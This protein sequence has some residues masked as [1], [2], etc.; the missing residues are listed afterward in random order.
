MKLVELG[1]DLTKQLYEDL[2]Y[3]QDLGVKRRAAIRLSQ[4][5]L[6]GIVRKTACTDADLHFVH[7][8]RDAAVFLFA[9]WLAT[10]RARNSMVFHDRIRTE[11]GPKTEVF[12]QKVDPFFPSQR[13]VLTDP[14]ICTGGTIQATLASLEPPPAL[15]HVACLVC[16]DKAIEK[17]ERLGVGVLFFVKQSGIS[18]D[19]TKIQPSMFPVWDFGD[20]MYSTSVD[21]IRFPA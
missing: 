10:P 19:G 13:V 11:E 4:E 16:T 7:V 8:M 20:S 9:S 1:N 2:W 3:N 21:R 14:V 6:L 18:E 5:V 15:P 12:A 17:L